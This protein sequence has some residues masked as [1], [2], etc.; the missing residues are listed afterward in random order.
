MQERRL[1]PQDWLTKLKAAQIKSEELRSTGF[2]VNHPEQAVRD[3]Y[4]RKIQGKGTEDFLYQDAKEV[5]Q[6]LTEETEEGR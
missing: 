2:P 3:L 6:G 1:L 4:K 5:F